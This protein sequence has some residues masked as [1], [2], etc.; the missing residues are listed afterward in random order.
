MYRMGKCG[1]KQ[2]AIYPFPDRRE[3][4]PGSRLC[5]LMCILFVVMLTVSA[6]A[7]LGRGDRELPPL[8]TQSELLR[9]YDKLAVVE[10]S[11]E[12]YGDVDDLHAEDYDWAYLALREEAAKIGA[13]AVILPEVRVEVTP[14]IL[15]PSSNI[16]AR[17]VAIKFR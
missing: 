12:R 17:G 10:V 1:R 11:R 14:Y 5:L 16:K 15:F 8:L 7:T 2:T 9:E 4:N 13:D 6:C 3:R